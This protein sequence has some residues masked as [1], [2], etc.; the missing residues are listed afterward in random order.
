MSGILTLNIAAPGT[1]CIEPN[2]N[3]IESSVG[4]M[5]Y[6]VTDS[7]GNSYNFGFAPVNP[8][9]PFGPGYVTMTDSATYQGRYFS[10][11]A[12][13]SDDQAQALIAFGL[14]TASMA[15]GTPAP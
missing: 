6:T 5:W 12:N 9:T 8:G 11:S 13:I 4:H 3:V 1:T 10:E 2:G 15:Q 7:N 14:T